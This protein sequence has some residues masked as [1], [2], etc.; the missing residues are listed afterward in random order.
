VTEE[1]HATAEQIVEQIGQRRSDAA[2]TLELIHGYQAQVDADSAQLEN[3][4]AVRDYMAFFEDYITR[5]IEV[6]DRVA[7][8]LRLFPQAEHAAEL[9]FIATQSSVEQRRCLLFRDKC[10]NKPLPYERM[11]PLLNEI[12]V[13]TR[14]QLT[15]FR[16]L[17]TAA[18]RIEQLLPPPLPPQP[19]AD[20]ATFDRRALFRRFIRPLDK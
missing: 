4:T 2:V 13:T 1:P 5:A 10:I 9:R 7:A 20:K 18:D 17:A 12:S 8:A 16:D 6:C 19:E 15:A 14:D 3:P 11:R